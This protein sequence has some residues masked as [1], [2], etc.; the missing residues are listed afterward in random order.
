MTEL[1]ITARSSGQAPKYDKADS[2]LLE[3]CREFYQNPENERAYQEWKVKRDAIT[4]KAV[5]A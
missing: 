2:A 3:L 4:T 1:R 5:S